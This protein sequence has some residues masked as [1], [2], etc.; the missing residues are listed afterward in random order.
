MSRTAVI[1]I[2]KPVT[3]PAR[4]TDRGTQHQVSRSRL[5]PILR[6]YPLAVGALVFMIIAVMAAIAAPRIAPH[7]PLQQSLL[8]RF[9]PPAWQAGGEWSYPLGTDY[10]GRDV[11]SR[12]L[13]GARTSLALSFASTLG[14]VVIGVTLGLLAALHGGW[15]GA[16]I[17]RLV[18]AQLA[19]PFIVLAIATVAAIG[20]SL[21]NLFVLLVVFGWA[22]FARVVRG[23][24]LGVMQTGYV[25]AARATGLTEWRI[26]THYILPNVAT[27]VIVIAAYTVPQIIIIES[28]LSFLGV[29]VQ[30]PTPSWGSML[31]EGQTYLDSAWWLAT[32]AGVAITVT[33]L[34]I[35][36]VGS[37]LRDANDP[38][39]RS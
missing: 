35:N 36:I 4:I 5:G 22:Q 24:T 12:L 30:P 18:D 31:S 28:A 7:D 8:L 23:E 39:R 11:L 1:A 14:S 2:A 26:A 34:A 25:E 6:S 29:G 21:L 37:A 16:L 38:R 32:S 19:F 17:M 9:L 27:P 33:V 10:L 20:T 3:V 13:F 15:T